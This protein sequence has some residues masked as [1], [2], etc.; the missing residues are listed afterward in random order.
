[1]RLDLAGG[2]GLVHD[3]GGQGPA[4]DTPVLG[5]NARAQEGRTT[6]KE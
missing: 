1:M 3:S 5:R 6:R 2:D 4:G